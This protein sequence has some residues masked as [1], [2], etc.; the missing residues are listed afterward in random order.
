MKKICSLEWKDE[1]I[2]VAHGYH[3]WH[4]IING[5]KEPSTP[6]TYDAGKKLYDSNVKERNI[7][8]KGLIELV[9][10][11]AMCFTSTK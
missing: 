11:K 6:P 7:I 2:C 9:Y 4:S 1:K 5:N 8:L 10:V 3:V